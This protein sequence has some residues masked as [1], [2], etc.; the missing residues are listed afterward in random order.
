ME[1]TTRNATLEDLARLL[2]DQHARKVDV[3]APATS[4]SA[5]G[6]R[7]HLTGAQPEIDM[8]GV[9]DVD[10]L[11]LPTRLA[12]EQIADRLG[13]PNHYVRRLREERLDLWDAN[14][15]GWL[16]GT[17]EVAPAPI[18]LLA[19]EIGGGAT[20]DPRS[21]LLRMFRDDSGVGVLRAFLSQ[22]YRIIDNLDVLTAALEGVAAAGVNV[23]VVGCDLTERRMSIKIAAPEV[24]AL[25]PVLLAN[26]R[27]PFD[28][29]NPTRAAQA[30]AHGWLAPDDRPTV[31]AGFVIS[32][33]E[34]GGGA[35]TITPRLI[36]KVCRNGLTITKD[37][38]R[39]VHLG[40]RLDEGIIQWSAETQ[41]RSLSLV[42]SQTRDAVATF[43]NVDY[44]KAAVAGIEEKAGKPIE[45]DP[46]KAV[47]SVAKTLRYSNE[48]TEAIVS[49]FVRSADLTAGGI[50]QAITAHAQ[51]VEDADV[52]AD[53]EA[54]G[55]AALDA[56]FALA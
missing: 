30:A 9:H 38:L 51:T 25:A 48:R 15:N 23:D 50:M 22:T 37:A 6:G 34:T 35:F 19:R 13:I 42:T 12:D 2:S 45:G 21:F 33:S 39:N 16:R 24:A 11:Y 54:D 40:G 27:T 8:E 17:V 49:M 3:V 56:A 20:P 18:E 4:L 28:D 52:A 1:L 10:G 31:F 26:Y 36:V 32:N 29:T 7:I 41:Q 46:I 47:Q 14:V 55:L 43:L 44:V 53:L 5:A